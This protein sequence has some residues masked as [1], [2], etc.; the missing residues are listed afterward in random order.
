MRGAISRERNILR[1]CLIVGKFFPFVEAGGEGEGIE[2][3]EI[4]E[5]DPSGET[6]PVVFSVDENGRDS[7]SAF[8][9]EFEKGDI[10]GADDM[11]F[12]ESF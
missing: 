10:Y 1:L 9:F 6:F 8:F 3:T 2:K 12:G 5:D 11:I 4:K 7:I